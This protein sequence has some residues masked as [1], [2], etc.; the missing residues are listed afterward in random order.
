MLLQGAA[1]CV[2]VISPFPRS[3]M[4]NRTRL[5]NSLQAWQLVGLVSDY[6]AW[7]AVLESAAY[8]VWCPLQ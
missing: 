3:F 6:C 5:V 8:P 2:R 1:L 4:T 7:F